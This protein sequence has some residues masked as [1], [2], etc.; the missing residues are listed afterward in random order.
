MFENKS[1]ADQK[2]TLE[3]YREHEILYELTRK[4]GLAL[5]LK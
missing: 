2:F 1:H 5:F 3:N 4:I